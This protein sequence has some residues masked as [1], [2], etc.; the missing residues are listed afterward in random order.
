[1]AEQIAFKK[2]ASAASALSESIREIKR[3]LQKENIS[4]RLLDQELKN[5]ITQKRELIASHHNYAEK[6]N[7]D[8]NEE[9]QLTYIQ[10]K[11]DECNNIIDD[12][13]VKIEVEEEKMLEQE[14]TKA[15][16]EAKDLQKKRQAEE[17]DKTLMQ[18]INDVEIL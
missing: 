6:G 3:Y 13:S 14:K 12:V 11:L 16:T 7:K 8:Q 5:V 10:P 15:E 4:K 1:M 17:L 2:R 18:E 9:E